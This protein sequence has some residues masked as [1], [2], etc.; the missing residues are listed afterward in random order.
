LDFGIDVPNCHHGLG[1]EN[2]SQG[3]PFGDRFAIEP[4]TFFRMAVEAEQLGFSTIWLGDHIMF[5]NRVE[6]TQSH[7]ERSK[8]ANIYSG[9]ATRDP[10]ASTADLLAE[11]LTVELR[12]TNPVY[13]PLT[14]MAFLGGMTRTIRLAVGTLVIPYR[15]PVLAAKMIATL[16][17]L[18]RGRVTIAAGVGWIQEE[19]DAVHADFPHRGAVTDDYLRV[20]KAV[21]TQ[22][23]VDTG[24]FEYAIPPGLRFYPQPYQKP[25][26]P[27]WVGGNSPYGLRRAARLGDGW[28][29]V[30]ETPEEVVDAHATLRRLLAEEGRDPAAFTYAHRTRFLV[31]AEDSRLNPVGIGTPRKIADDFLR[32]REAGVQHLQLAGPP[33]PTTEFLVEQ[34]H[35]FVEDVRPLLD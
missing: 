25:H 3:R 24:G 18:S 1:L 33:G 7:I 6:M 32:L 28:L 29:G 17:V 13:D 35:R 5:P 27:L 19:F 11:K 16:D 8:V 2:F 31:E 23:P 30:Y 34:M 9:V 20:M 21:W 15:P 14:L 10:Q 12:A 22:D 26:P 4:E